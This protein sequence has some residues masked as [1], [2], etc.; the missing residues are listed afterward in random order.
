MA[1]QF[2]TIASGIAMLKNWYQGPLKSQFNDDCNIYR[3]AELGKES[4]SGLQVIRP[5]KVRRNQ[6]VGATGD[7]GI[8]PKIGSQGTVQATIAS[9]F[10][11][12]RFG[13]TGPMIKSSQSDKGS[14]V[15]S[16]AYELEE[17]YKDLMSDINRAV[18]MDSSCNLAIVNANANASNTI[19]IGGRVTNEIADKFI[20]IQSQ[21]DI[22][23]TT[24]TI[25]R[26]AGVTVIALTGANTT[27]VTLGLDQ[28]VTVQ[29]TDRVVHAGSLGQESDG[30]LTGLDGGTSTIFGVNRALYK[31]YQGSVVDAG[32][33]P[34]TLDLPNQVEA[35]AR[36]RGGDDFECLYSD[37]D[38][39]RFYRRLLLSDKRYVNTIEGDG[40][41]SSKK[42]KYLEFGGKPWVPD[43]DFE[44]TIVWINQGGFTKYI[45]AEM[46]FADET[47]SMMIAQTDT[48]AFEVRV[49]NFLTLFPEKPA[50]SGRLKNY[51]SP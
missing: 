38:S 24:G 42:R 31:Q 13:L 36:R 21:L 41:F 2:Q 26:A 3:G 8:L 15:R 18:G 46:D 20:D 12:L 30:L 25:L 43:K 23:D 16:A 7:N 17:G 1:N 9:K 50:G 5:L 33:T 27:N 49:R 35:L 34:L 32:G 44:P 22:W 48:D 51:V 14:F 37:F 40:G 39:E 19:T 47:G 6:G 4:W 10:H 45:L 28:P 11:Y 29:N